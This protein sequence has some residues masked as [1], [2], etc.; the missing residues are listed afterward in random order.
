M[1]NF[2]QILLDLKEERRRKFGM[3]FNE[4]KISIKKGTFSIDDI[5]QI[6]NYNNSDKP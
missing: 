3:Y 4:I 6:V 5:D 1:K 2:G